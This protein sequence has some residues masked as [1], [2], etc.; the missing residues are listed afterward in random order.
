M[1]TAK[2][3]VKVESLE[4]AYELNQKKTNVIVGGICW[5]K[6]GSRQIQTAIDLSGLGLDTIEETS[7]SFIIGCM[8]TLRSL[9]TCRSL[10]NWCDGAIKESL[11]H[12]VGVQ[13]RNCATIGGSIYGRFGFSDI[14]TC[15]LAMDTSVE[16]Y[17]AGIVPLKEFVA[18]PYDNDIL[19]RIIIKKEKLS[20]SYQSL[21]ITATDFPVLAC[22]V[23]IHENVTRISVGAR[24][25][26]AELIEFET[27]KSEEE[28][29]EIATKIQDVL[30]FGTNMRGSAEYRRHLAGV[31][32]RR[33]LKKVLEG[34]NDAC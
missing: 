22:A 33:G 2:N 25:R 10:N 23:S 20:M 4:Q 3:Y 8:A 1:F 34:I 7:D 26:R 9:E 31:F 6:L 24:P 11:R 13:F 32:V 28:V 17:K 29:L 16:L 27:P 30:H 21:R 18:M 5:L 14:L 15:L 12:I 19:V